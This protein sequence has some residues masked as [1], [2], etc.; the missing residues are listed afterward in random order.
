MAS[1]AMSGTQESDPQSA[2]ISSIYFRRNAQ[3]LRG[4]GDTEQRLQL[5]SGGGD[6]VFVSFGAS[7]ATAAGVNSEALDFLI[8]S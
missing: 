6:D 1:G 7:C 3:A 4:V 2:L 5:F 8:Q